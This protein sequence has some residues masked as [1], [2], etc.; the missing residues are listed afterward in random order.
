MRPLRGSVFTAAWLALVS[1]LAV[2]GLGLC[3][4]A[5]KGQS[6]LGVLRTLLGVFRPS[7]LVMRYA[8]IGQTIPSEGLLGATSIS[9]SSV[10]PGAK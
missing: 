2:V 5:G 9:A 6:D 8:L 3:R 10:M 4:Y 1:G 7:D